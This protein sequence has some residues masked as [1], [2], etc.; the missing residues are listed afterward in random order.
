M[1]GKIDLSSL[2]QSTRP[3]KRGKDD[4]RRGD[5]NRGGNGSAA[6]DAANSDRKKRKRI[7]KEKV[8]IEKAAQQPG[9]GSERRKKATSLPRASRVRR[10]FRP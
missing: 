1:L 8:D 9:F 5:K 2:N 7:G 10:R 3:K 6:G 4:R